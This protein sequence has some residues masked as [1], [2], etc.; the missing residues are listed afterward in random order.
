MRLKCFSGIASALELRPVSIDDLSNVRYLH[1]SSYRSLV[2]PTVD[3]DEADTFLGLV[4][5]P[6]Y[7]DQILAERH[8]AAWLGR[9]LV[10]SAGWV[11]SDDGTRCA[12]LSSVFVQPMFTRCGVG[13]RLVRHVEGDARDMG[14]ERF[15]LKATENSV[16]F[17]EKLGYRPGAR[18]TSS[19]SRVTERYMEKVDASL[20]GFTKQRRLELV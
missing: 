11:L 5:S 7:A 9:E 3:P 16:G 17:W 12:R 20:A 4:N 2:G 6:Y 15:H 13:R 8:F 18:A 19:R 1:A 10:G 14:V